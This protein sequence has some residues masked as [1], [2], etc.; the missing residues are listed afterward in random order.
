MECPAWCVFDHSRSDQPVILHESRPAM[1]EVSTPRNENV[2]EWIDVQTT[3]YRPEDPDELLWLPRVE[4]SCHQGSRYR[5]TT[6]SADEARHL[7]V[8]LVVAAA[9]ADDLRD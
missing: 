1:V 6:L 4:L 7:A 2:P 8:S 9:Y 3:Q 5:V